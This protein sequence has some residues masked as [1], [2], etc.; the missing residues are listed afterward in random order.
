MKF[1]LRSKYLRG[2]RRPPVVPVSGLEL[3]VAQREKM[4]AG[5]LT[6]SRAGGGNAG[7]L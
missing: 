5:A 3:S 4:A 1:L 2:L 7:K 6:G